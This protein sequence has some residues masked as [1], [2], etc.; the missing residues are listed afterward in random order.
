MKICFL[1]ESCELSGGVRVVLDLAE[2]LRQRAHTVLV[3]ARRGSASWYA[4]PVE[5]S[6]A[7]DLTAFCAEHSPDVVVATFWTTLSPALHSQ[8]RLA[9]HFCQGC[10]WEMPEYAAIKQ[11]IVDAY[12]L[13]IPKIT[14]GDW[15][16]EKIRAKT[17]FSLPIETI[18]QCV[19]TT[20]FSPSSRLLDF[21]RFFRS[22]ATPVI[23]IPGIAQ[24][25]VKGIP[26]AL[27]A[28]A[29][30]RAKGE[31]L[32][33]VRVSAMPMAEEEAGIT[34]IDAYHTAVSGQTMATLYREADL[35]LVPSREGEGFG[36][37]FVEAIA[38]GTP[39]IATRIASFTK[40]AEALE[41]SDWLVPPGLPETLAERIWSLLASRQK[42]T[43]RLAAARRRIGEHYAADAVAA[44][45]EAFALARL[46]HE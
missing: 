25:S 6:I 37:P 36:L 42:L 3:A 45:F 19:D 28:V 35:V 31:A 44:R 43:D 39:A 34:P 20:L 5:L 1:L 22:T 46:A 30:C 40:I 18:G 32:R 2:A 10:E 12:A 38:A 13:P 17:G 33:V 11:Q 21:G 16:N 41:V 9:L 14:V 7:P 23:L 24:A 4:H 15:L 29:L 8:H 27:Q 26:D